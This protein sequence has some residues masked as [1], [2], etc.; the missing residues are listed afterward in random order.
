MKPR[1]VNQ[2][3]KVLSKHFRTNVDGNWHIQNTQEKGSCFPEAISEGLKCLVHHLT[4]DQKE[5]MNH[6]HELRFGVTDTEGMRRLVARKLT[7]EIYQLFNET[8]QEERKN[9]NPLNFQEYRTLVA[10]DPEFWFDACTISLM[11][12]LLREEWGVSLVVWK[13]EPTPQDK[14]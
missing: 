9:K 1:S 10:V 3:I 4:A 11:T 8:L 5:K 2:D 12:Q 6:D 13:V 7:E 14:D